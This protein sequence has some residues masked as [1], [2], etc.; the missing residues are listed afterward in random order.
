MTARIR[1]VV[2][3]LVL[4]WLL[5]GAACA[6]AR[7]STSPALTDA[8]P[9]KPAGSNP[10]DAPCDATFP[11][12][13]DADADSF[14]REAF[15]A[16]ARGAFGEAGTSFERSQRV[17]PN[18][19]TAAV[20]QRANESMLELS[21][22]EVMASLRHVRALDVP[23][24]PSGPRPDAAAPALSLRS[25]PT[26][27]EVDAYQEYLPALGFVPDIALHLGELSVT[28]LDEG[29]DFRVI[30]YPP[31]ILAEDAAGLTVLNMRALL[32]PK[33]GETLS[34]GDIEMASGIV[35]IL[36]EDVAPSK[37]ERARVL[38]GVDAKK[39]SVLWTRKLEPPVA[40]A[41]AIV[42]KLVLVGRGAGKKGNIV[43]F[44]VASGKE[45]MT[46]PLPKAP[47]RLWQL[48]SGIVVVDTMT[49]EMLAYAT[50]LE[51]PDADRPPYKFFERP[52]PSMLA[53]RTPAMRCALASAAVALDAR[54]EKATRAA[55][56]ALDALEAPRPLVSAV[57]S[58]AFLLRAHVEGRRPDI[59]SN[60]PIDLS[61]DDPS[62][63]DPAAGCAPVKLELVETAARGEEELS[64]LERRL[65]AK[66]SHE[67]SSFSDELPPAFGG[68]PLFATHSREGTTAGL[69][70]RMS[71]AV[72]RGPSVLGVFRLPPGEDDDEMGIT[73][74]LLDRGRLVFSVLDENNSRDG[75]LM[76]FDAATGK[77]LWKAD[78]Q[79][80]HF[81]SD[82]EVIYAI[83]LGR[84]DDTITGWCAATGKV[85]MK[86]R[87]DVD[88]IFSLHASASELLVQTD[89]D[90]K[91][92]RIVR[93]KP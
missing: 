83:G 56:D 66:V 1:A 68:S 12:L 87:V 18:D 55:T 92:F 21:R 62:P 81:A 26:P 53:M 25:I 11:E 30:F 33:E 51:S 90:V 73:D 20:F 79:A 43:G 75:A 2:S 58:A 85:V 5:L 60:K 6:T 14:R 7:P 46:M 77:L 17:R 80:A 64:P 67:D 74:A 19:L 88:E 39:G 41:F 34:F 71:I 8:S 42:G 36:A 69:Y 52:T 57:R 16:M 24:E 65:E 76:T 22:S 27:P 82:G 29:R 28:Y 78:G 31:Y 50:G 3:M 47:R 15:A 9:S 37:R 93:K 10:A 91:L 86:K 61:P 72:V 35:V 48:P 40:G 84:R 23:S 49:N 54:D 89:R 38:M 4:S 13:G 70:G 32:G 63:P 45:V 44:D 59:T